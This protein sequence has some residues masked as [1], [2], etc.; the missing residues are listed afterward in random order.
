M[1]PLV[2]ANFL[3]CPR[4]LTSVPLTGFRGWVVGICC[5]RGEPVSVLRRAT[6]SVAVTAQNRSRHVEVLGNGVTVKGVWNSGKNRALGL[7]ILV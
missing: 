4:F 5:Q 7:K 6:G 3:L 2:A 1:T